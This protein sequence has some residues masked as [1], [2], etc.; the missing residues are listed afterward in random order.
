MKV[1]YG[2]FSVI[3]IGIYVSGCSS[4]VFEFNQA[5]GSEGKI[6]IIIHTCSKDPANV[7]IFIDDVQVGLDE[8][9]SIA[10]KRE[11]T[12]QRKAPPHIYGTF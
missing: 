11:K 5:K 2:L 9:K 6:N 1:K 7:N 4:L 3:F 10:R 12:K 8:L